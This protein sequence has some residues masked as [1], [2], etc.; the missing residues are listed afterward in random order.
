MIEERLSVISDEI[1]SEFLE[2]SEDAS[3]DI[4]FT[5]CSIINKYSKIYKDVN[6]I[7]RH[8]HIYWC[9]YDSSLE[10]KHIDNHNQNI[11]FIADNLEMGAKNAGNFIEGVIRANSPTQDG[12]RFISSSIPNRDIP[13]MLYVILF[14][15]SENIMFSSSSR[16]LG[17]FSRLGRE[18]FFKCLV[19]YPGLINLIARWTQN[20]RSI[21][22]HAEDFFNDKGNIEQI[23]R[24]A[25][26]HQQ[27]ST[28]ALSLLDSKLVN[29][30]ENEEFLIL[31]AFNGHCEC[32]LNLLKQYLSKKLD[33]FLAVTE[34]TDRCLE[35]VIDSKYID[36]YF[37]INNLFKIYNQIEAIESKTAQSLLDYLLRLAERGYRNIEAISLILE[38]Q[39]IKNAVAS[40]PKDVLERFL[41]S[42]CSYQKPHYLL[43]ELLSRQEFKPLL[44]IW[45]TLDAEKKQLTIATDLMMI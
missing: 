18:N 25:K 5:K 40:V 6:L 39:C 11:G 29:V 20:T 17:I 19:F 22:Q 27:G 41:T 32:F 37:V 23:A 26:G 33:A 10:Q 30:T 24:I 42:I 7:R 38:Q 21:R 28:I 31:L 12:Y 43:A 36:V 9:Q 35:K 8:I 16:E 4:Q 45:V 13:P 2:F 34:F 44:D 15:L 3:E 1:A 14:A